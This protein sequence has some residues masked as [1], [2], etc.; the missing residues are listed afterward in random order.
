MKTLEILDTKTGE[1]E[2]VYH[3]VGLYNDGRT[4]E[5]LKW[6]ETAFIHLQEGEE[7]V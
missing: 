7:I 5:Y 2:K 4:V 6:G 1:I 3:V